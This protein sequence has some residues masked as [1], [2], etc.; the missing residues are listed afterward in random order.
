MGMRVSTYDDPVA[1]LA[2]ARPLLATLPARNN[3]ALGILDTLIAHPG[4]Y[5]T[6]DLWLAESGGDAVGVALRTHPYNAILAEPSDPEAV[7]ALCDAVSVGGADVPGVVANVPWVERFVKRWCRSTGGRAEKV[8][9]Q[10]V[11]GLTQV[12]DPRPAP[13]AHR[14]CRAADRGL[15]RAWL[16]DFQVEALHSQPHD[17]ENTE[18]MLD[19][20]LAGTDDAGLWFWELEG[21]PVSLAGYGSAGEAGSRI[22]PV[23][24]PSGR[25][26]RGYASNLV[27]ELSRWALDRGAAACCLYTDLANPTSNDIYIAVGYKLVAESAEYRFIR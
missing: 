11:Y 6:F 9:A 17:P 8:L 4:V 3:L 20:R 14:P 24:T 23:F 10:G 27:A 7:D 13:G 21:E 26:G 1:F 12:R 2:A 22:G 18:R 19:V 15:L 5:P 16:A 25:R